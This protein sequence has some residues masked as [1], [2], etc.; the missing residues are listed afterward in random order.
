MNAATPQTKTEIASMVRAEG[1]HPNRRRGQSF[2]I[3]GNLMRLVVEAADL[4]PDDLVL[5]VGTG[6]GSLTRLLA[7][8]AGEVITVEVEPALARIAESSLEGR[9]NVTRIRADVLAG[10]NRLNPAVVAQLEASAAKR[11]RVKLVANLPYAVATPVIMNLTLEGPDFERMVF[12]VQQEVAERLT[13]PP[14]TKSYGWVSVVIALAGEAEIVRRLPPTAF[15]PAPAVD[16]ALVV[17]RPRKGWQRGIDLD[18]LRRL[19]MFVFQQ[20]RK[21]VLRIVRNYLKRAGSAARAE[22]AL[23][24]TQIET[25]LRG[26]QLSPQEILDLSR[27]VD[28]PASEE[29]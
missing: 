13:A 22:D 4:A 26:D 18:R 6:T 27:T 15:W 28:K 8:A 16:S 25:T 9:A 29:R 24:R 10:K 19:G 23:E 7:E 3:D 1:F 5:E 20:R 11:P 17:F 21:T 2:L 12:T 14:G